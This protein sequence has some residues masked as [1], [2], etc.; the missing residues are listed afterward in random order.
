M[1]R[2]N[3][4]VI[5][6]S[7]RKRIANGSGTSVQQVNQL[8]QQHKQM[9][10]M[11]K[12]LASGKMPADARRRRHAADAGGASRQAKREE[13][14]RRC[15]KIRLT[16]VGNKKN[17]IYRVVVADARAPRDGRAIETIGRYNPQ[18]D[19]VA[20]RDRHRQGPR[21]DR[22]GR[23][24]DRAPSRSSSRSPASRV[25]V[26][27]KD[28]LLYL[29]ASSCR[30]PTPSPSRRRRRRTAWCSSCAWPTATSAA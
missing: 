1:E 21:V 5:D 28:V 14:N 2:R 7:R 10:K 9:K 6:G 17:P 29:S 26:R 13:V 24:A 30:S 16:R 20:G 22:Q 18:T 8:L 3:P 12:Q 19:P 27:M 4:A 15:M 11:M 25:A 23:P